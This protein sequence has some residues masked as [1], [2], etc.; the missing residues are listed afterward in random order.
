MIQKLKESEQKLETLLLEK[1]I[2]TFNELEDAPQAMTGE[3]KN[4]TE[5]QNEN[6]NEKI[7]NVE[8]KTTV[9]CLNDPNFNNSHS[10]K[11][12][13]IE[14][15]QINKTN[16]LKKINEDKFN[17]VNANLEEQESNG[18][19]IKEIE[20]LPCTEEIKKDDEVLNEILRK[21]IKSCTE[22]IALIEDMKNITKDDNNNIEKVSV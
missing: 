21:N 18:V 2:E 6:N 22:K 7:V 13:N 8:E 15:E 1:N 19:E 20:S 3:D 10:K 14:N 12:T 4:Q 16:S 5:S 9:N 17:N 11:V